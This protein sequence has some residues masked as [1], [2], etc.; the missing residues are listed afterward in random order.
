MRNIFVLLFVI[1]TISSVSGQATD[2]A[3]EQLQLIMNYSLSFMALGI[4][5]ITFI[6]SI[7]FYLNGRKLLNTANR[8][9]ILT[10]EKANA[11]Q[12]ILPRKNGHRVTRIFCIPIVHIQ[13]DFGIR[14]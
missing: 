8:V 6:A 2:S 13:L 3:P 9:M 12:M 1:S 14:A 4:S 7:I 10:E 5:V 11:M